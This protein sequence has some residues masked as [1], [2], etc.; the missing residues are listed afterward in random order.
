MTLSQPSIFLY[1]YSNRLTEILYENGTKLY[2]LYILLKMVNKEDGLC[3]TASAYWVH[4][5]CLSMSAVDPSPGIPSDVSLWFEQSHGL[6]SRLG[7]DS[8]HQ[9]TN[10]VTYCGKPWSKIKTAFSKDTLALRDLRKRTTLSE[11]IS[12]EGPADISNPGDH[13]AKDQVL[14]F[15]PLQLLLI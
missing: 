8:W 2:M 13:R 10:L 7:G 6:W 4:V 1:I 3:K 12:L 9:R 5:C 15:L 11:W 14:L